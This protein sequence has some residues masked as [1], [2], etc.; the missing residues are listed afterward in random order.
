MD[1]LVILISLGVALV[2]IAVAI[3]SFVDTRKKYYSEYVSRT[4]R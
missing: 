1:V 3:W 4:R 2:G